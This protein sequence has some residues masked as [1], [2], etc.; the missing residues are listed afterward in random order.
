MPVFLPW[1][2]FHSVYVEIPFRI[3]LFRPFYIRCYKILK[4]LYGFQI[5]YKMEVGK[6]FY[7]GYFGVIVI[8][9]N[10][11]IGDNCNVNQEVTIGAENRGKREGV[12]VIGNQVWIGANSVIVGN[13]SIGILIAPLTFVNFDVPDNSIVVGNPVKIKTDLQATEYYICNLV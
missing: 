9:G 13:I 11:K 8:N 10:V 3:F 1:F 7:L 2:P 4:V 12:P 6:G 5:S